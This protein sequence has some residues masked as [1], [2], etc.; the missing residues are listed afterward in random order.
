MLHWVG[1]MYQLKGNCFN[2]QKNHGGFL[3]EVTTTGKTKQKLT[4]PLIKTKSI[5]SI[6]QVSKNKTL[7]DAYCISDYVQLN[8]TNLN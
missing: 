8:S 7:T 5:T 6:Q 3:F 1:A 2:L 4:T